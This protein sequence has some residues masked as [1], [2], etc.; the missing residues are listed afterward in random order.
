M[1]KKR[2][3]S[4]YSVSRF[5]PSDP[6][7]YVVAELRYDSGA[8]IAGGMRAAFAAPAA[9][10]KMER[11]GE[12]SQVGNCHVPPNGEEG[13]DYN[14]D[15]DNK[16][17]VMCF[18][19]NWARYPDV[20]GAARL[21]SNAEWGNNQFCY[22]KWILEHVPKFPGATEHGFDNGWVYV[23]STDENLPDLVTPD[24]SRLLVP[25]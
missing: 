8:A 17:R 10:E 11:K 3:D 12:P 6:P 23:A 18:A 4:G 24:P 25:E 13:Y 7:D 21:V 9:A 16:R 15:Y 2:R 20:R 19:D 5:E 22:Q 14:Y 1:P